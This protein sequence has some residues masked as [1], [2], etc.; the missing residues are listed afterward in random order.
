MV[1]VSQKKLLI[2]PVSES[3]VQLSDIED[4]VSMF[5]RALKVEMNTKIGQVMMTFDKQTCFG[6]KTILEYYIKS[7]AFKREKIV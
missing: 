5:K 4:A 3:K 2:F 7:S 6:L 1:S